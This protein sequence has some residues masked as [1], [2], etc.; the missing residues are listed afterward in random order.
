MDDRGIPVPPEVP[1]VT[2]PA[3]ARHKITLPTL[4]PGIVMK[5]REHSK[6]HH[7]FS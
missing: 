7:K 4:M 1:V 2:H 6:S 5:N 3:K